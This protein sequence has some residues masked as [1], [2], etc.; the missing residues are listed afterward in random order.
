MK[1]AKKVKAAPVENGETG[2]KKKK[3]GK[4]KL[5][6]IPIALVLVAAIAAAAVLFVLP[7]FGINLLGGGDDEGPQ[8]EEPLPKKGVEAYTV[9]EDTVPSLDTI[10]EEGEGELIALRSPGK[11]SG[12]ESSDVNSRYTYIYELNGCAAIMD[13][14]LDILMGSEQGFVITDD[15]YLVQEE[16]PELQDAEGV[17]VLVRASAEEGHLFQLAIGW[18]Q[19]SAN[20]AV[21]VSAPEGKISYPEKEPS[22][23][24]VTE[25]SSV[26]MQMEQIRSMS[27]AHLGLSGDSMD[28]YTI[29]PIDGFVKVDGLDCRRFNVYSKHDPGSIAAT[30]FFSVDQQHIY[31]LNPTDNSVSTIK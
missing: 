21:R 31:M 18:S 22:A 2:G 28:D 26:S 5:L 8:L 11:P 14:Y 6:L 24:N 4:K 23:S 10:L 12:D 1:K 17:L 9:G 29:F 13:R 7:K 27:P 3:G 19:A 30:Y 15:T 25:P 20:L 16:R